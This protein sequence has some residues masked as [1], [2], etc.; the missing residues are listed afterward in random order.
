MTTISSNDLTAIATEAR[1][2]RD[3][4]IASTKAKLATYTAQLGGWESSLRCL[5]AEEQDAPPKVRRAKL[6]QELASA[7]KI[8][9]DFQQRLAKLAK[10]LTLLESAGLAPVLINESSDSCFGWADKTYVT[11]SDAGE[12]CE[13]KWSY[14]T[15]DAGLGIRGWNFYTAGTVEWEDLSPGRG[16]PSRRAMTAAKVDLYLYL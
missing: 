2:C 8:C 3:N 9:D 1:K 11:F 12:P 6:A 7:R 13:T 16:Y 4:L 14:G 15:G 10:L 5:L